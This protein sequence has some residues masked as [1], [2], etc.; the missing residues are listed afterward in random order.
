MMRTWMSGL[1][2]AVLFLG[3]SGAEAQVK[4][5]VMAPISGRMNNRWKMPR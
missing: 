5:G 3:A 2:A 4:F 1:A